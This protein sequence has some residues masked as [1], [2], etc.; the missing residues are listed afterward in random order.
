[1]TKNIDLNELERQAYR[2]NFADGLWD[3]FLGLML[4][5]SAL[6]MVLYRQGWSELLILATMLAFVVVVLVAFRLAKK[7][8]ITPRMGLVNFSP[9]REAKKRNLSFV[10]SLSVLLGV[11]V[12]AVVVAGYFTIANDGSFTQWAPALLVPFAAFTV[13]SVVVFSL[14]A[15]WLDFSRLYL[16][17]WLFGLAMPINIMLDELFGITFPWATAVFSAIMVLIGL[18]LFVR[19]VRTHPVHHAGASS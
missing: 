9:A 16:Y 1:M 15:Y 10:L 17:G 2:S 14:A 3:M 6:G 5:Q 12:F 8:I 4:F 19:F 13:L 7:H 11:I 18:V